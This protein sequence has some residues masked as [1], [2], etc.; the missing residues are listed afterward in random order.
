G[1]SRCSTVACIICKPATDGVVITYAAEDRYWGVRTM[2]FFQTCPS[3]GKRFIV[4]LLK[5]RLCEPTKTAGMGRTALIGRG[6]RF[7]LGEPRTVLWEE[8]SSLLRT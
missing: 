5:E 2:R 6:G 7:A 3:V 1:R 8:F 4:A